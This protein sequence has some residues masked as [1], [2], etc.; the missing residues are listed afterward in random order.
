[1]TLPASP[2][3]AYTA[4]VSGVNNTTGSPWWRFM[5]LN[6]VALKAGKHLDPRPR[7]DGEQ[8]LIGGLIVLGSGSQKVL[9]RAIGPSLA[10][11]VPPVADALADPTLE[12]YDATGRCSP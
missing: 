8:C 5:T 9:V 3:A 11:A 6:T 7:A 1:M 12:L 10:N 2:R 4:I